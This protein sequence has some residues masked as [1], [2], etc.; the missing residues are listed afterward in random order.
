MSD[1]E[2]TEEFSTASEYERNMLHCATRVRCHL[3]QQSVPSSGLPAETQPLPLCTAPASRPDI[4]RVSLPKLQV[5]T[6]SGQLRRWQGWQGFWQHFNAAV[7]SHPDLPKMQKFKYLLLLQLH[8]NIKFRMRCLSILK[9]PP[10]RC[11]VVL[12]HIRTRSLLEDM[13]ILYW[14]RMKKNESTSS[15]QTQTDQGPNLFG[16]C[17]YK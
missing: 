15:Q 16:F 6:F 8:D 3:A 7:H 14:Q 5:P 17:T 1:D 2:I 12:N 11:A 4:A 9:V 10:R 13:V